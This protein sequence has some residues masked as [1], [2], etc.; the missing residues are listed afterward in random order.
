MHL[1]KLTCD[2]CVEAFACVG[3]ARFHAVEWYRRALKHG[4]PDP[5]PGFRLPEGLDWN[6][7]VID[8]M[9]EQGGVAKRVFR[10]DD[11]ARIETVIIPAEGRTTLCVSSQAGCRM[12]CAF[13]ATGAGGFRR[14][15][16]AEEIVAQVFAVRHVLGRPVDN[17]VFM[18]MGEPLDNTDNVIQAIRVLGDQRGFDIAPRH[19][20]VSTA[21]LPD[22]IRQLG[23]LDLKGLR[24][25]ISLNAANDALRSQLMPVN[26]TYPLAVLK[27][28]LQEYPLRK[29]G[30]YFIEYVLFKGLNDS[31]EHAEELTGFLE[32]LPVRLNVIACN[33][34]SGGPFAGPEADECRRFCELLAAKG[35]FVRLRSSRGQAIQAA[36]GQLGASL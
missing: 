31:P 34:R 27:Q 29:R 16:Q 36:C 33:P 11:G 9:I 19:I 17:L 5:E 20:T 30:V 13:C 32:G 4:R 2:E 6:A 24:L 15:L 22:G 10:F 25:A 23:S 12:G 1:F 35:V 28:V 14:D 26:R 3:T 7:P 18:G 8:D 21:G